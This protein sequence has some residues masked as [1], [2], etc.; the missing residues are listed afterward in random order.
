MKNSSLL[1]VLLLV[2]VARPQADRRQ[3]LDERERRATRRGSHRHGA[4]ERARQHAPDVSALREDPRIEVLLTQ[5]FTT[6]RNRVNRLKRLRVQTV[7][8]RKALEAALRAPTTA[9]V[10]PHRFREG[11]YSRT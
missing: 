10:A 1:F 11:M 7:E 8:L 3:A 4:V 5:R 2:A 9:P 6:A